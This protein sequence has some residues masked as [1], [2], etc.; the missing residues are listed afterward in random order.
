MRVDFIKGALPYA[1]QL[2]WRVFPLAKGW[3]LPAI[4]SAHRKGDP[5]HG[6]CRGECGR[7]G[8]GVYDASS[9]PKHIAEWARLF[10]CANIG[11]ACGE[12]SGFDVIDIDPRNAGDQTIRAF[13]ARGYL[14][15]PGP[16]QRTG[17]RGWHM[18]F[19]HEPGGRPRGKLGQ[20]IDVKSTGGY[21]LGAPSWTR[22]SDDGDG[23]PYFW[24]ISP[25]D[26][27]LPK[28]PMWMKAILYPPPRPKPEFRSSGPHDI[29]GLIDFVAK[30]PDGNRNSSLYWAARRAAETGSLTPSAQRALLDAALAAGLERDKSQ[31]TIESAAKGA[32]RQ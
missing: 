8:H 31:A 9:D 20:G 5:E 32:E 29:R 15:P 24:E 11:I 27:P 28:M 16:R 21:I 19:K 25:F 23:G 30:S 17:N 26:T 22:K 14:V 1:E 18:L 10:P 6:L 7:Q 12:P 2:G 3:K 13:A 4:R